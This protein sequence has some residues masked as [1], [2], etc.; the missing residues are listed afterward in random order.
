MLAFCSALSTGTAIAAG[1]GLFLAAPV[2]A[3]EAFGTPTLAPLLRISGGV[4]LFMTINGFMM[5]A[6]AGLENYRVLG[7]VG[8][9]SGVLYVVVE[10]G[11]ARLWGIEGAVGGLLLSAGIQSILLKYFLDRSAT[12][13][14]PGGLPAHGSGTAHSATFRSSRGT[15]RTDD[16]AC[17][18]DQPGHTRPAA[19]RLR[20]AGHLHGRVQPHG[21]RTLST[22]RGERRGDVAHQQRARA[23]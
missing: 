14:I 18:L 19:R 7:G 5:G 22:K 13:I 23:R 10:V 20:R 11:F 9:A 8:I 4:C 17:P 2:L 3:R 6:L 1:L 21:H 12:T 16:G 15:G